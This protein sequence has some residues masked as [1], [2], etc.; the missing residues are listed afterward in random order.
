MERM[1]MALESLIYAMSIVITKV[2]PKKPAS[3]Y[4]VIPKGEEV[5][6]VL[7]LTM[8]QLEELNSMLAKFMI[9][10]LTTGSQGMLLF[11][12]KQYNQICQLLSKGKE[13][14]TMANVAT[15]GTISIVQHS[16]L[17]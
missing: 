14:D 13:V 7:I 5:H 15:S 3:S 8:P 12:S 4:M 17:M 11:T 6:L 16:C 1:P 10:T 9:L 2:T